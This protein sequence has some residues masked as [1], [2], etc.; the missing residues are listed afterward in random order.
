MQKNG[1]TWGTLSAISG[2]FFLYNFLVRLS[3]KQGLSAPCAPK[4]PRAQ[5]YDPPCRV[6]HAKATG[7]RRATGS[8]IGGNPDTGSGAHAFFFEGIEGYQLPSEI[9]KR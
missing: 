8:P 4:K 1:G 9:L 3:G 7:T 6:R 2:I 5:F